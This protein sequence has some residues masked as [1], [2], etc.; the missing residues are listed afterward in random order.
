MKDFYEQCLPY[1]KETED[2]YKISDVSIY[3]TIFSILSFIYIATINI[4]ILFYHNSYIFKRQCISYYIMLLIG[5]LFVSFDSVLIENYYENFPC[6]LHHLLTAIGYPFYILSVVFIIIKY[7]KY[8]YK[9]QIA[10]F[11]SFLCESTEDKIKEMLNK[12]F[13]FKFFYTK[14]TPK[15]A[16][17][18]S[19]VIMIASIMYS[20]IIYFS[21][22]FIR[23]NGFCG[24]R[25][26]YLPQLVEFFL[27][28]VI[29]LPLA[30]IEVLKFDDIFKM[31]KYIIF[32]ISINILYYIGFFIGAG[33]SGYKCSY[34]VQYIPPALFCILSCVTSTHTFTF[35]MLKN[36]LYIKKCN[37]NLERTY[38]GM[39]KM[40]NDKVQFNEF[41]EFC[42]KENCVENIL[43]FDEYWKYKKLFNGIDKSLLTNDSSKLFSPNSTKK[44]GINST[45]KSQDYTDSNEYFSISNK[46]DTFLFNELNEQNNLNY[47]NLKNVIEKEA[48]KFRDKFIGNKALYEINI[49]NSINTTIIKLLRIV[50]G[51]LSKTPEEKIEIYYTVF[52]KAYEEVLNNIYLN[53][54]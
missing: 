19:F 7:Y 21:D 44:S 23:E 14:C 18:L 49:Q 36:I 28:L 9:S 34:M 25:L 26:S 43:F 46:S 39:I 31:K 8:Y 48:F 35:T 42:I 17:T 22:E 45:L 15:H 41:G 5:C 20:I 1:V 37:K 24:M 29:F 3:F 53:N 6:I 11:N 12:K 30:L 4:W 40:L 10:Y 13:L 47:K 54:Y 51:D 16:L 33:V 50:P 27:F 38:Q 32:I 52:D 2:F